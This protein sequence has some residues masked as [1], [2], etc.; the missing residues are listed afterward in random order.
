VQTTETKASECLDRNS[1]LSHMHK[2]LPAVSASV[3]TVSD[4]S[5][6]FPVAICNGRSH[7]PGTTTPGAPQT[8]TS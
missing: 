7:T 2:R 5:I 6:A 1:A 4:I 3:V 8:H